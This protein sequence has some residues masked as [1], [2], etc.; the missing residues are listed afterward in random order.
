MYRRQTV[1]WKIELYKIN[2]HF[3][4][5]H[6]PTFT[7]LAQIGSLSGTYSIMQLSFAQIAS[8]TVSHREYCDVIATGWK[9]VERCFKY[10]EQF[11]FFFF[12]LEKQINSTYRLTLKILQVSNQ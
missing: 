10:F 11:F 4:K 2:K 6:L 3:K 7:A 9:N 12:F 5:S 1:M 8:R